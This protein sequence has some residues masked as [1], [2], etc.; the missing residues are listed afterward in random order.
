MGSDVQKLGGAWK[1]GL[2]EGGGG[3]KGRNTGIWVHDG[4]P[5][6]VHEGHVRLQQLLGWRT[7]HDHHLSIT[8]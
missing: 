4:I 8:I 2:R 7:S 6:A 1:G 5:K 3:G